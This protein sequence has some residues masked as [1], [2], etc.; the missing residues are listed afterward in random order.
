VKEEKAMIVNLILFLLMV[1]AP[2]LAVLLVYNW[3]RQ[4]MLLQTATWNCDTCHGSGYVVATDGNGSESCP[5]CGGRG[6]GSS[7]VLWVSVL[8]L[9]FSAV[10][11]SCSGILMYTGSQIRTTYTP[12]HKAVGELNVPLVKELLSSGADPNVAFRP[13]GY[14]TLET[15]FRANNGRPAT[16]E[17]ITAALTVAE[18]L[19]KH[20]AKIDHRDDYGRTSLYN[21]VTLGQTE[22][23]QFLLNNGAD[24]NI[25][26]NSKK[27]VVRLL[28]ERNIPGDVEM[29]ELLKQ[30][31]AKE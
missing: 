26:D 28:R 15:A 14:S 17:R 9:G 3:W 5:A 23:I 31:G 24:P 20:G 30:H 18:L 21:A 13:G 19:L 16:P 11:S 10:V 2:A 12:L 29:I 1:G 6:S 8:I 22:T 27:T 7:T 25:P 4:G